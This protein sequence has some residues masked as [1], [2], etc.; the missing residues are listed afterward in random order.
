MA[1]T[2]EFSKYAAE[3]LDYT[4]D[5]QDRLDGDT[6]STV[7]WTPDTGITLGATSNT[8]T[9]TTARISGGTVGGSYNVKCAITT[10]SGLTMEE[11]LKFTIE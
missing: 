8:T 6:I 2:I 11:L 10:A 5:W 9:T 7:V 1:V 4:L 3:D